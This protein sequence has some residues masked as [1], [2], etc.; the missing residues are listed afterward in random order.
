MNISVQ[1]PLALL[2]Y[3]N[4]TVQ[5]PLVEKSAKGNTNLDAKQESVVIGTPIP[6][7]F[8]RRLS[9]IGGV[10]VSPPATEGRFQNDGTTN[11]LTVYYELV[12]SQGELPQ[13]AVKD[14]FQR[15]CR[16]GTWLQT[17][18]KRAGTWS[19]G[20]ATTVVSG[21]TPW[22]APSFCGTS[23]RYEDMTMMSYQNTH[24]D[25]DTTFD[26]QVHVFVREGIKVTRILDSTLG[27]SNNVVDLALYLIDKSSRLPSTLIDNTEMLAAATFTNVNGFFYNG[28]FKESTN[29]EDW[30]SET[31]ANFLLRITD[32]N[33]KKAFRPR[34]PT[35]T[36]G[37]IKTTAITEVFGF[38][39]EHLLSDGF[40]ISYIPASER[41]DICAL[42][43]WRQQPD[44]DIGL[45]RTA[46]IRFQG[47]APNGA[48]EQYDLSE[49]CT[50]ENHA[51]KVGMY[52]VARKKFITHTVR[53]KVRPSVFNS[54]LAIGD[55]VRVRLRRE[56]SLD[57]VSFHDFLYE[58][59]RIDKSLSGVVT[60]DLTH[61]PI[62]DSGQSLVA[63]AVNAATGVGFTM[64]TGKGTFTCDV[65]S[66][67][68]NTNLGNT[69]INYADY[70]ANGFTVPAYNQISYE[71]ALGSDLDLGG[72][73]PDHPIN[74][75]ADP[76]DA[77][78]S[79]T[80]TDNRTDTNPL[81][82]GDT[83][84]VAPGCAGGRVKWYRRD[85]E[86]NQR[87]LIQTETLS[88]SSTA[89]DSMSY[90]LTTEDIDHFIEAEKECPDSSDPSGFG[91]VEELQATPAIEPNTASYTHARFIYTKTATGLGSGSSDINITGTTQW[92]AI[93][94]SDS[95][96][97]NPAYGTPFVSCT[98]LDGEPGL[99]FRYPNPN[100]IPW[101]STV[102]LIQHTF[103]CSGGSITIG[104]IA[105]NSN[106]SFGCPNTIEPNLTGGCQTN[107]TGDP[108]SEAKWQITGSWEFS[109]DGTNPVQS[110]GQNLQW[111]GRTADDGEGEY[112]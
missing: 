73:Q 1:D 105:K 70:G 12:L 79:A 97:L 9:N 30:L 103:N 111:S 5:S 90:S 112:T 45:I 95:L 65:N 101:R 55:I 34:L 77:A 49:Y 58:V 106:G 91:A 107:F 35:N 83:L 38:T 10:L 88:S 62:N 69:G 43:L 25:G 47:K 36:N 29:L 80:I 50:S 76:L 39:E 51:V 99:S 82:V 98:L 48:F 27:A 19:P 57:D 93:T 7:V 109:T 32:K 15:A 22:N 89:S 40:E 74:N 86:T 4:G 61:F 24:A 94:S 11:V 75:N 3:Q 42:V 17:Y 108:P 14:V 102:T 18:D 23:G 71:P 63:L 54:T 60:L 13:I 67:S 16:E 85:K 66:S 78:N 37:T 26:K 41:Q 92:Y 84:S 53:I 100:Y 96:A 33:G 68:D 6:I 104:G 28:V 64:P 59:E 52:H 72:S 110:G 8:C 46:E 87:T 21:K 31:G 56:T 44:T 20:N 81:A 2:I